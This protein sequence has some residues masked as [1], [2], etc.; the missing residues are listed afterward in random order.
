M[1]TNKNK[2]GNLKG[3]REKMTEQKPVKP[4]TIGWNSFLTNCLRPFFD[5]FPAE[6]VRQNNRMFDTM[7]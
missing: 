7:K 4:T 3:E 5:R 2:I 1:Q 6:D